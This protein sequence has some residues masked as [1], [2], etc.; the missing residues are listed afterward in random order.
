[1]SVSGTSARC[2]P[3]QIAGIRP[4]CRAAAQKAAGPAERIERIQDAAGGPGTRPDACAA[5]RPSA[6]I[7]CSHRRRVEWAD[8]ADKDRREARLPKLSG[9]PR[10]GRAD[11]E[12]RSMRRTA[13]QAS[14]NASGSG[15][16]GI[17]RA[18]PDHENNWRRGCRSSDTSRLNRLS[19]RANS[20]HSGVMFQAA[21]IAID[22]RSPAP[23]PR[24]R[25][26]SR[27]RARTVRRRRPASRRAVNSRATSPPAASAH[28]AATPADGL[29]GCT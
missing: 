14:G 10:L 6:A 2:E 19:I 15:E 23:C 21:S 5:A 18:C 9:S 4:E 20:C 24:D 17:E 8:N 26:C 27:C 22:A 1:M 16:A 29:P 3:T 11:T 7:P 25:R 12:C 13:H 28:C